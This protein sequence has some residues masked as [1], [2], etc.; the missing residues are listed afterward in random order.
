VADA[1][2]LFDEGPKKP[3]RVTQAEARSQARRCPTC[4]GVV[5]AGMSL[6]SRCGLD[7][8][9]GVQVSFEDDLAPAP[10]PQA[11]A[12]PLPVSIIG[13]ISLLGS[14][15]LTVLSIVLWL[16]GFAGYQYFVPICLFGSYASLQ[17]LRRKSVRLLLIALSF[18][19]AIDLVALIAMPIHRAHMEATALERPVGAEEPE[20]AELVLPSVVDKLDTQSLTTGIALMLVYAGVAFYLMTPRVQRHFH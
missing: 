12:L 17:L 16:Q 11:P 20:G 13:G 5:P 18:G 2:A 6:C 15:V 4:G 10:E 7:L 1:L 14:L 19:V 3:R 8:E 9:T